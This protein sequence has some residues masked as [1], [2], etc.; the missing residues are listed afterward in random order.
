MVSL[1]NA[2]RVATL[3]V[4][5]LAARRRQQRL[6]TEHD[7]DI[8]AIQETKVE[9][10]DQTDYLVRPFLARYEVCGHASPQ[11]NMAAHEAS[12]CVPQSEDLQSRT[13][14]TNL[15]A[16]LQATKGR[17]RASTRSCHDDHLRTSGCETPG[18]G[19]EPA[20][21]SKGRP[22]DGHTPR[23]QGSRVG[24]A[25]PDVRRIGT[26]RGPGGL[27]EA[28]SRRLSRGSVH[29]ASDYCVTAK[30]GGKQCS[31]IQQACQ[32]EQT[33]LSIVMIQECDFLSIRF[34]VR[35]LM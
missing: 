10:E 11:D 7:L 27:R 3:N 4:R 19:S 22:T 31:P 32:S 24:V 23:P 28:I 1:E 8:V 20:D 17:I 26:R 34:G 30:E 13:L 12:K 35:K 6:S 2:L 33:Q 21:E 9:S 16:A 15:V 5:G 14:P 29:D 25:L 18:S